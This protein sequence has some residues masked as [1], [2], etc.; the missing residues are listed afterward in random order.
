MLPLLFF[1]AG[2][3][4]VCSCSKNHEGE[5]GIVIHEASGIARIDD[6]LIIVGDD[7]DGRYYEMELNGHRWPIIPIDPHRVREVNMPHAELASDLESIDVLNDGRIAVL[8]EHLRCLIA[9]EN[10]SSDRYSVVAEYDKALTEFGNRG[11]EGLSVKR[12][13]N[14]GSRIAVLWEGGYPLYRLV[15]FELRNRVGRFPLRPVIVVHDIKKG[16]TVALV[17]E[18]LQT[19]ILNVPQPSG[20]SPMAQRFRGSDLVWHRW[21]KNKNTDHFEEGFIVLL[22]SENSPPIDGNVPK[23]YKQKI[24]QRFNLEGEPV[25]EPLDVNRSGKEAFEELDEEIFDTLSPRMAAHLKKIRSLFLEEDWED[26]NWEG[27]DWF[28]EGISVITIY[29][30]RRLDPPF[31]LVVKLPDSWK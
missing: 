2:L 26:I 3:A 18:P 22:S 6:R 12:L 15:P 8:S 23:E 25:G 20:K 7:A 11:L 30:K 21:V 14:G 16:E 31:A 27:L 4:V 13:V 5:Q 28:E 24:L 29:D 9:K 17:D 10:L 1:I 19:L